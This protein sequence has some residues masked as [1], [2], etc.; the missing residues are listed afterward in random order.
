MATIYYTALSLDGFVVDD[1]DSLDWLTRN[2]I[3]RAGFGGYD[4]FIAGV[5]AIVMG[6][7]TYHW[8]VT[9]QPDWAYDQPTWVVTHHPAS[10]TTPGVST[11]TGDVADLH[12]LLQSA[13]DGGD[14]WVMGGGAVAA[15]FVEHGL[16]DELV[17]HYAPCTL[18]SGRPVLPGTLRWQLS[19]TAR[20]RDFVGVRWVRRGDDAETA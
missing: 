13:A 19:D 20:N 5:G 12:P 8:L 17:V 14:V 15:Q 4:D 3:D 7:A 18:G 11:F 2:D 16:V 10:I 6:A 1:H 9:N